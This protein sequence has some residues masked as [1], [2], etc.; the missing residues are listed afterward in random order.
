MFPN[1][2]CDQNRTGFPVSR[3]IKLRSVTQPIVAFVAVSL[4]ACAVRGQG[5]ITT[6][7][8]TGRSVFDLNIPQ[9]AGGYS[10]LP[11][12]PTHRV[13]GRVTLNYQQKV[14]D[15]TSSMERPDYPFRLDMNLQSANTPVRLAKVV[16]Q[17]PD[18]HYIKGKLSSTGSYSFEWN[19]VKTGQGKI[20]VWSII[21]TPNRS[22]AVADWKGAVIDSVHDLTTNSKD[23]IVFSYSKTFS[24]NAAKISTGGLLN[25]IVIPSTDKSAVAFHFL[26]QALVAL[27]YF[28]DINGVGYMPKLN[29][30]YTPN[31]NDLEDGE[32]GIYLPSKDPGFIYLNPILAWSGFAIR[33]EIAHVF[34]SHYMRNAFY[35]R[36]GEPLANVHAAAMAGSSL[37]D[38]IWEFEDLDVQC[39]WYQDEFILLDGDGEYWQYTDGPFSGSSGWVQRVL[40][41]LIDGNVETMTTYLS[42]DGQLIDAG[43]FDVINGNGGAGQSIMGG[44]HLLNDVLV[45]YVGGG[46]HGVLNGDYVDRGYDEV[47][48]VDVL[49]GMV[50]FGHTNYLAIGVLMNDAME[51]DFEAP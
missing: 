9:A 3:F 44:D 41:D 25:N 23:Y 12:K 47:D 5:S 1:P 26:D 30:V 14:V 21:E 31:L 49:D 46:S 29:I 39:N 51:F 42:P 33:H 16:L 18:G 45:G 6:E 7:T 24:I 17:D 36:M 48:I 11:P 43:N 2:S 4:L 50:Y 37:M 28:L 35:G 20:T 19:P 27:D 8:P 40:W 10:P 13:T 22:A 32:T 34:Q 38:K 15:W